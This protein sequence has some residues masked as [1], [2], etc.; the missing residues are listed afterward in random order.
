MNIN[1]LKLD[2]NILDNSKIKIIRSYPDGDSIVVLWIGILCLA[3]KSP[4]PGFIEISDGIPYTIDDLAKLFDIEKKTTELGISLLQ[5]FRMIDILEGGCIDV[6][7]FSREQN[8]EFIERQRELTRLRVAK[9]R[10]KPLP[11]IQEQTPEISTCNALQTR[12]TVTVTLTDKIR[13]DKKRKETNTVSSKIKFLDAVFL[14]QEEINKLKLK[15]QN[16]NFEKAIEILNNYKMS[17]GKKY[18]SDYHA[19]IG[20]VADRVI[21]AKQ[22]YDPFKGAL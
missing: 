10:A 19:L 5:K 16:G 1:W 20:W 2:V 9:F 21:T 18:K 22:N 4:K 13:L 6:I 17:S 8:I 14:T 15:Y 3:M 7:N 11:Q 12:D